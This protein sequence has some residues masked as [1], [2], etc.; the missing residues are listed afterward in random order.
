M[1]TAYKE[2]T[3]GERIK[4]HRQDLGISQQECAN[5]AGLDRKTI[6]RIEN[7]HFSPSINTLLRM[8]TVFDIPA[9]NIIKG[10]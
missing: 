4:K 2:L 6:N 9:S 1:A 8:A 3:L 7:H 5:Y 10:L